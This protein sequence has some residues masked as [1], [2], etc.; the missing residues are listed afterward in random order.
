MDNNWT[1]ITTS[2]KFI[3]SCYQF[4]DWRV[5]YHYF[6][7]FFQFELKRELFLYSEDIVLGIYYIEVLLVNGP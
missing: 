4:L 1:S 2:H 5:F 3:F 7:Q 6:M